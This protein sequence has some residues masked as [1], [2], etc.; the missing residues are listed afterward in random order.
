MSDLISN[1][2]FLVAWQQLSGD[3]N[4]WNHVLHKHDI[5]YYQIQVFIVWHDEYKGIHIK[6]SMMHKYAKSD[7]VSVKG[8]K[9]SG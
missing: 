3:F 2:S 1:D 7:N 5:S 6:R 8:L 4:N 9:S